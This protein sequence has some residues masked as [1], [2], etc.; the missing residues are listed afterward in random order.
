MWLTAVEPKLNR[1]GW[2][3][4]P[5]FRLP[6]L[7][8]SSWLNYFLIFQKPCSFRQF[9]RK[10]CWDLWNLESVTGGAWRYKQR[11]SPFSFLRLN[12]NKYLKA[13]ICRKL[14]AEVPIKC[15][16]G[17]VLQAVVHQHP[18][19]VCLG[20]APAQAHVFLVK[21]IKLENCV[22]LKKKEAVISFAWLPSV[23]AI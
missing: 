8:W 13:Q 16:R 9:E 21:W 14:L 15:K 5:Y 18:A 4:N 7:R 11:F 22:N 1:A 17:D 2:D 23:A 19:I 6:P 10:P 3:I 20:C 12:L